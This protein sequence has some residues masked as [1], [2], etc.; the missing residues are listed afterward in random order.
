MGH[1]PSYQETGLSASLS[2]HHWIWRD[3]IWIGFRKWER[4]WIDVGVVE[5]W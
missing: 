3:D 1:R 2:C 5:R 4:S